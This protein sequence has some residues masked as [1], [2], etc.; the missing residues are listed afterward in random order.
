MFLNDE[1]YICTEN[2]KL[3]TLRSVCEEPADTAIVL[4]EKTIGVPCLCTELM[5]S[6][7]QKRND[8]NQIMFGV[9]MP[10][11]INFKNKQYKLDKLSD[12]I[13]KG[14]ED[15]GTIRQLEGIVFRI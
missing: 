4:L 10:Y 7:I 6:S 13:E 2:K 8:D 5:D 14:E 12:F 3:P 15:A 9:I 11:K 1:C